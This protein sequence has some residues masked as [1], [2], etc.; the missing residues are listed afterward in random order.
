MDRILRQADV[1]TDTALCYKGGTEWTEADK[2][3]AT[4]L[5]KVVPGLWRARRAEMAAAKLAA[6]VVEERAK[7]REVPN[8]DRA[9]HYKSKHKPTRK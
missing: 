1:W 6:S 4:R 9:T 3:K 7:E 2:A 5:Q 8:A